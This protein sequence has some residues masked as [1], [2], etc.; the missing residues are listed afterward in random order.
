M[1]NDTAAVLARTVNS[2]RHLLGLADAFM[3]D[4]ADAARSGDTAK[5]HT[6]LD[7]ATRA[8]HAAGAGLAAISGALDTASAEPRP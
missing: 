4:A 7:D 2:F 5:A 8:V 3:R 6:H 1:S